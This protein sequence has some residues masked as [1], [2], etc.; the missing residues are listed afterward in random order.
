MI[1]ALE[2]LG[3]PGEDL[4]AVV[5]GYCVVIFWGCGRSDCVCVDGSAAVGRH[6]IGPGCGGGFGVV[7]FRLWA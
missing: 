1:G 6:V 4:L 7:G 5:V 2:A 3:V